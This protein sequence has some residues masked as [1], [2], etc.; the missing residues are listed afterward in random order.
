[1]NGSQFAVALGLIAIGVIV[2]M[3]FII[4]WIE[5]PPAVDP[6]EHGDGEP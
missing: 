4:R 6:V 3:F 1:M 2:A 5:R